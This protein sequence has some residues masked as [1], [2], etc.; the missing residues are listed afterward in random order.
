MV[1]V[2]NIKKHR[3]KISHEKGMS[4]LEIEASRNLG[5]ARFSFWM[6]NVGYFSIRCG[7]LLGLSTVGYGVIESI[8]GRFDAYN[9][10]AVVGG[11]AIVAS[12]NV[13]EKFV[14]NFYRNIVGNYLREREK[15][16]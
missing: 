7:Q 10:T 11:T 2:I 5:T 9:A 4:D 15:Y 12:L 8:Q 16:R 14:D 6:F 3:K 1:E 13:L